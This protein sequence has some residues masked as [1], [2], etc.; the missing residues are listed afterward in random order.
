MIALAFRVALLLSAFGELEGDE[1]IVGLMARHILQGEF[2]VF[3]WGQAYLGSL[4]PMLVALMFALFGE[5]TF[6]LKLGPTL[7]SVVFIG[8]VFATCLRLFGQ[9]AALASAAY[10]A[11]PPSFFAI[12]STKPRGSYIETLL[13]GQMLIL[14]AL[15]TRPSPSPRRLLSLGALAGLAF[16][17]NQ[18]SIIYIAPVAVW[19]VL[20]KQVGLGRLGM[21]VLG[22]VVGAAPLV[23]FNVLQGFPTVE[24]LLERSNPQMG[25]PTPEGLLRNASSFMTYGLPVM[26]GMGQATGDEANFA[27]S[28]H[29][30]LAASP[31]ASVVA[32]V[33]LL[34]VMWSFKRELWAGL[35][36]GAAHGHGTALLLLVLLATL[37]SMPF[38][39]FSELYSEP[40]YALPA[41]STVPLFFGALWKLRR[42]L[43]MIGL[44]AAFCLN[45][46]SLVTAD[47]KLS[48]ATTD[49]DGTAQTRGELARFLH[50]HQLSHVYGDYWIV[51]PLA[52]ETR[53]QVIPSVL[54][55]GFD[56]FAPHADLVRMSPRPAFIMVSDSREE[57]EFRERLSQLQAVWRQTTVAVYT[58]Y[59]DIDPVDL[60]R[61]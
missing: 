17:A 45:S 38:T 35:H 42:S 29:R 30:Y 32:G 2:S 37:S 22:F 4:E 1:A 27:I 51:Y 43:V 47:P 36:L 15:V 13:L 48:L 39:R 60:L 59:Y 10:L 58:V 55:Y 28:W 9:A 31:V 34:C 21:G 26:M 24:A 23:A 18:L 5:S 33:L 52:F 49:G 41:Y 53:E 56:R 14:L 61:P 57:S 40:R 44:T 50:S 11:L 46:Y 7:V 3:Y 54:L 19:V 8:L 25:W 20:G 6:V 16:W 12:W